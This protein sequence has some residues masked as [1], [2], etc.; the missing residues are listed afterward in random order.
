[1]RWLG[2]RPARSGL[3]VPN[4]NKKD[5]APRPVFGELEKFDDPREARTA[6]ESRYNVGERHLRN[7]GDYDVPWR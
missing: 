7:R 4:L 5:A 3:N 1:M 2:R 6:S